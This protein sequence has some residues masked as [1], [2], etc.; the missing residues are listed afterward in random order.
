MV[1]AIIKILTIKEFIYLFIFGCA[2]SIAA[3]RFS[4]VVASRGYS[5]LQWLLE[6]VPAQ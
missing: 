6:G 3:H 2:E 1:I 4:L 5:S